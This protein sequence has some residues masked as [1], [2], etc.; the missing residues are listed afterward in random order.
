MFIP[1]LSAALEYWFFKVNAGPIALIVD[2][3][4]RRKSNEH[5]LRA[6]V[7]SPYK[8]EVIFERL[9]SFMPVD[10]FMS[11]QRTVGHA[12][13]VSWDL[14]ITPNGDWFKPD[15]FPAGLLKMP[16][17]ASIGAPFVTFT[18]WIRHGSQQTTLEHVPG[19]ITQYWGRQ[20]AAEWW[21]V[22]AHQFDR[23]GIAVEG[24]ILK[25]RVWGTSIQTPLAFLYLRQQD[26]REY[27]IAPGNLARVDGTPQE[28]QVEFRRIGREKVTL[29]CKGRDYGDFGDNII[30]TLTG[31]MELRLG[32]R[33]IASAKGTAGLER[34][35][36]Y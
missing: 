18:G 36:P 20:L 15:I 8:R 17:L 5:V 3:I 4:E 23:D 30:N 11:T 29:I 21:W 32:D 25:S 2:W 9:D 26:K 33:V 19:S 12:G 6:S 31:D 28:F 7:H 27:I 35:G 16:D 10:N 1:H 24:T 13:D 14:Q 34:L 22:S